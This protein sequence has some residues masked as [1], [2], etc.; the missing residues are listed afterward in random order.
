M[1]DLR[2]L[3]WVDREA[4]PVITSRWAKSRGECMGIS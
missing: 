1:G 3:K 4:K 2:E